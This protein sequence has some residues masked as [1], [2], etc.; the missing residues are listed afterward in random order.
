MSE[1][2]GAFEEL[3]VLIAAEPDMARRIVAEHVADRY[4]RCRA[5]CTHSCPVPHPCVLAAAAERV[6]ID[7]PRPV[8]R[9]VAGP[10]R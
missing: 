7:G 5:C 1:Q 3:A 9:R 10:G 6:L 2:R 4:G 8:V